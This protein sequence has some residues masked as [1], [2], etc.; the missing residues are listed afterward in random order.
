MILEQIK[1][2][3]SHSILVGNNFS[4]RTDTL[5]KITIGCKTLNERRKNL[6]IPA[7]VTPSLSGLAMFV[8][9]ELSIHGSNFNQIEQSSSLELMFDI[10]RLKGRYIH[11]LSG[12]EMVRLVICSA[13]RQRPNCVALDCILEQID[14]ETRN[15]F[16]SLLS[17]N[18]IKEPKFIIADN[19]I[20]E[21]N[22][23]NITFIPI[24]KNSNGDLNSLDFNV[25]KTI[26]MKRNPVDL[27]CHGIIFGYNKRKSPVLK[28]IDFSFHS[29]NLYYIDGVNGAGKSTF[30][31]LL[32]GVHIPWEGRIF[33]K[34]KKYFPWQ[35]GNKYIAYHFQ[36][37]D[38]GR[39]RQNLLNECIFLRSHLCK[40]DEK[41]SSEIN[42]WICAFGLE[43]LM[44]TPLFSLP[45]VLRKRSDICACFASGA[46]WIILDEPTIGQDTNT[47]KQIA[48]MIKY[49]IKYGVGIIV[50]SHSRLM[51]NL[52]PGH[53][54]R[55]ENGKMVY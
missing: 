3:L 54:V 14:F 5:C 52:V 31:R 41:Q 24:S 38:V 7:S 6:F 17:N 26:D 28:G 48:N 21:I 10:A 47:V 20:N 32:C 49:L 16:Y 44:T 51:Q 11:T 23:E 30:S 36:N 15:M 13:L 45:Y 37:P 12:G 34:G 55:I 18:N 25:I 2:N 27:E 19:R 43:P 35:T 46:P 53:H 39:V 42:K 33:V 9:H 40:N 4:G 1:Q 22:N 50:I 29:G 8:D